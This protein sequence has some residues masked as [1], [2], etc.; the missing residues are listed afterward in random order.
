MRSSHVD[1]SFQNDLGDLAR[2]PPSELPNLK[3]VQVNCLEDVLDDV[4]SEG[5]RAA[6]WQQDAFGEAGI[7]LS[8]GMR[9]GPGRK[10]WTYRRYPSPFRVV[11]G[12]GWDC[13]GDMWPG[14]L[15]NTGWSGA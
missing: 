5:A 6:H 10:Y 3:S 9:I 11:G 14:G 2:D 4:F 13:L 8:W 15:R 1:R 12:L 7:S